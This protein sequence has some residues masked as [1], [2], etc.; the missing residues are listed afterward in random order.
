VAALLAAALAAMG[1]GFSL[2]EVPEPPV[3][4]PWT[5]GGDVAYADGQLLADM[6]WL[7]KDLERMRQ[8]EKT[9][10]YRGRESRLVKHFLGLLEPEGCRELSAIEIWS[11]R[12]AAGFQA[13]GL[14]MDHG[15]TGTLEVDW[16]GDLA[17]IRV[18]GKKGAE[19]LDLDQAR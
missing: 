4:E 6:L 13:R 12:T 18:L 10:D 7:R 8:A 2:S 16:T 11:S 15:T 14:C 5:A 19:T 9:I 1:L 17:V 3:P